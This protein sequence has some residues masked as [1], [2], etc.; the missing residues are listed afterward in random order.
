MKLALLILLLALPSC[1]YIADKAVETA[2]PY[3]VEAVKTEV[4]VRVSDKLKEILGPEGFAA[5]DENKDSIASIE[6]MNKYGM[7][8]LLLLILSDFI[9]RWLY[10]RKKKAQ[11]K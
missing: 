10:A 8:G 4:E 11:P 7:G 1:Q 9:Q 6:E 2:T 5:I 3:I